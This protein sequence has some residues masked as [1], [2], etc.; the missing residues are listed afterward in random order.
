MLI[1]IE[2]TKCEIGSGCGTA[3][4]YCDNMIDLEREAAMVLVHLAIFTT[5]AGT[6]PYQSR[7]GF[8]HGL[9]A[10]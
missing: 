4:L 5:V 10:L 3:V 7:Q 2:A 8:I 9:Q 1:P 6:L